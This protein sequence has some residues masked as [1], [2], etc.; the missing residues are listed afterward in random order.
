MIDPS[1]TPPNEAARLDALRRY[2]ILDTP[3]D[4][5]FDRVTSLAAR[6]LG[7]PIAIISLVDRDRI[8]FKSRHGLDVPQIDRDPGLCASAILKDEAYVLGDAASDVRSLAN[9]LVAGDFGLRFY[10]GIPLRTHDHFNLGV[11]CCLDFVPRQTQPHELQALKDLAAIVMDQMELR[12]AARRIDE[13]NDKLRTAYDELSHQAS[14][15]SLT[16]LWNRPAVLAQL[17]QSLSRARRA[18]GEVAVLMLDVDHFKAINDR[19]GHQ[20]GDAV[21]VE[22]GRRLKAAVRG[23]DSVG[24]VGGEEFLVVLENGDLATAELVAQRCRRSI[25]EQPIV[26]D[27]S[28][29]LQA[30]V[31]VSVGYRVVTRSDHSAPT[32]TVARA[33]A[34]LYEAKACGRNRVVSAA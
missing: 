9:P 30:T 21:L 3:Q 19:F 33:D 26:V 11:L 7:T 4:G 34:A 24:R 31:T 17:D 15:D 6:I 20:G 16:G 22:I 2:D 32:A 10:A 23:G 13:L 25:G 27:A 28:T 1:I 14:H 8:W 29:G 5:A 12:L 18:G